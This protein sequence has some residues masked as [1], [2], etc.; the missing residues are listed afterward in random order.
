MVL[1][2]AANNNKASLYAYLT[3]AAVKELL[4]TF[5][6]RKILERRILASLYTPCKLLVFCQNQ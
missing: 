4:D 1:M 5:F 2:L 6:S 3:L